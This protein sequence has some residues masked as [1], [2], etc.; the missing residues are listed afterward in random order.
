MADPAV[1]QSGGDEV[2]RRTARLA[3]VELSLGELY[4]RWEELEGK[5]PAG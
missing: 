5:G 1:Y 2:T 3:E 4:G